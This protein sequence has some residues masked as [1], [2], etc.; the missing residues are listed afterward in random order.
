MDPA[1]L[2]INVRRYGTARTLPETLELR[3]GPVTMTLENADLRGIRFG[4]V[5]IVQRLYVAIRDQNWATIQPVYSRFTVH[6]RGDSFDITFQAENRSTDVDFMWTGQIGGEED[7]TITYRMDGAPRTSFLR[8][9]IGFCVLHPMTV[10]GLPATV[11]TPTET[12]QGAFPERISPHQPFIDMTSISHSAGPDGAVT[13]SFEGDLFEVEDQRNWTD[14]S[15]KTYGTP[16]RIPYPV[17]VTPSERITQVVTIKVSGEPQRAQVAGQSIDVAIDFDQQIALPAIGFGSGR[18]P[19]TDTETITLLKAVAPA[20]LLAEIDLAWEPEHWQRRLTNAAANAQAVEAALDLSVIAGPDS[21]CW[22]DLAGYLASNDVAVRQIFVFP[23]PVEPVTFP[24]FDLV[25]NGETASAAREAFAGTNVAISGGT[26]AY[27]TELNRGI[28]LVPKGELAGIMFTVTPEVHAVDNRSVMENIAAQAE[29]VTSARALIEDQPLTIGP[30]TFMPPYNPNATSAPPPAGPDRLPD[31]VDV[32]QLSLFGAGWT[33]GSLHQLAASGVDATT[34][35]ELAGWR[36]LI[37]KTEDLTRRDLFPSTP[38]GLFPLYHVF[39]A[40]AEFGPA[41]AATV[42]TADP[43]GQEALALIAGN[44]VR[45]LIANLTNAD[46]TIT[47][48]TGELASAT[49]SYLDEANYHQS[50]G[51]AELLTVGGEPIVIDGGKVTI[52]LAPYAIALI[53]GKRSS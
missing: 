32:R 18:K 11:T 50:V 38:G 26:R 53:D 23:A 49:I 42:E 31:A 30:I 39:R 28:D 35:F 44:R 40:I 19:I 25:T 7:G 8:N 6:N 20:H 1:G 34:W 29:A 27:F 36:G 33:I 16:L 4:D 51:H 10:A 3:A 46:R 24:R 14:A 37:E 2:P 13:I 45:V 21:A 52:G 43:I 5:E 17:E 15:F 48:Y 12:I 9:R 47:I 41:Q 22:S